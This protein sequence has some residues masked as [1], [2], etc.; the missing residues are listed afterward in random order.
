MRAFILCDYEGATGVVSW[1]E[2]AA[3]GPEAMAGDVNAVIAGLREGGFDRFVV[4]DYHSA[5]RT[6]RLADLDPAATLIR[7]KSTP[8]PYGLSPSFDAT[9]FAAAHAMAGTAAGV[10]SHTMDGDVAELRINDRRIG[11]IGGFALLAGSI[12]VPIILVTGDDAA[13]QEAKE[14]I[15]DVEVASVKL[16]LTRQCAQC[17]H[18]TVAREIIRQK[19]HAAAARVGEFRPLKWNPPYVLEVTFKGPEQADRS[20]GTIGGTRV[21]DLTIRIE[22]ETIA[23]VLRVFEHGFQ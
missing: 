12:D 22:G 1:E 8:F 16:G 3:L 10:M 4:R 11:E 19:A 2:E 20:H 6:V 18:P 5:G 13:C 14:V 17:L 23:E 9:V 7:G 15:G 21:N